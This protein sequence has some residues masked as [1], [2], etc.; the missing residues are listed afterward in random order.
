M[1][2]KVKTEMLWKTEQSCTLGSHLTLLSLEELSEWR[3]LSN[4]LSIMDK[5]SHA[6]H[7]T[8]ESYLGTFAVD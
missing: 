1:K 8:L 4:L 3:M 6:Q 2:I 5:T 7:A